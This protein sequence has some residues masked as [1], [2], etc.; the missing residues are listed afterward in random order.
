MGNNG[1]SGGN[2]SSLDGTSGGS[3][4]LDGNGHVRATPPTSI[5][6]GGGGE[7]PNVTP[8]DGALAIE[9]QKFLGADGFRRVQVQSRPFSLIPQI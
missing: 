1:G 4:S 5:F 9:T 3:L 2:G 6:N 8:N 7:Y